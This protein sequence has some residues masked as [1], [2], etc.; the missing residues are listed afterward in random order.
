MEMKH[1][2][3]GPEAHLR[4]QVECNEASR[5]CQNTGGFCQV[6]SECQVARERGMRRSTGYQI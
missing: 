3:V 2:A 5:L 4:E 6:L 1:R